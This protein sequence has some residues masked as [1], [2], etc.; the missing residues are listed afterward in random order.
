MRA[1]ALAVLALPATAEVVEGHFSDLPAGQYA[2]DA[3]PEENNDGQL[4]LRFGM[5]PK[6]ESVD[7]GSQGLRHDHAWRL[8]H[9]SS[10]R[11]LYI[12]PNGLLQATLYFPMSNG[13][14][15][16]KFVRQVTAMQASNTNKIAFRAGLV[17]CLV[18]GHV[19]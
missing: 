14:S 10:A 18:E 4:N 2:I 13:R 17:F 12:D 19:H 9:V 16:P 7:A 6:G 8:R 1:S 5:F 15:I 3:Y 11:D